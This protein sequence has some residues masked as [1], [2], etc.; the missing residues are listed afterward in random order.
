MADQPTLLDNN[1]EREKVNLFIHALSVN[2]VSGSES[3]R[4]E[5]K[6]SMG[7]R[8]FPFKEFKY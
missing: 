4:R 1:R 6:G 7:D 8:L 2:N 5:R 3:E